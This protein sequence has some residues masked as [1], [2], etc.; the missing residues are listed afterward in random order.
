MPKKLDIVYILRP[1]I[2]TDELRYSLRSVEAN[3]PH[4]KVWFVCGQPDGFEP[5]GRIKHKQ[6]GVT[7]WEKIRSSMWEVIDTSG[8]TDDFYLFND[9]FFVMKPVKGKFTN[10]VNRSLGEYVQHLREH[11][12]PWLNPYGRTVLKAQQELI[13]LGATE[14]NFEV[15]LP[16]VFNKSIASRTIG[17]CSSPQMRSIYGNLSECPVIDRPDVKVYGLEEIP[18]GDVD[19]LS[20]NDDTFEQG[21]VGEFIRERFPTP[22]K[23]EGGGSG[24]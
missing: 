23:W 19:Y 10:Y 11:V 21:K 14:Y 24:G 2:Q 13:Q 6:T 9:D 22:S 7:K 1:D 4:R 12:H 3:L 5:D 17:T 16:M 18:R 15:H 20:T 8:V